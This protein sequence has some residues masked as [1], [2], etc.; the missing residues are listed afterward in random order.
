MSA[1]PLEVT[2]PDWITAHA[3]ALDAGTIDADLVLPVLGAQGLFRIGV[4]REL[5][6]DGGST[7]DAVEAIAAVASHSLTAAFVFWGQRAF[8][9]YLLA[10]PNATLRERWLPSLLA[11]EFAGATGLSN[12]MKFLS[13]IESLQIDARPLGDGRWRLDGKLPW[14]TNLRRAGFVVA[15]AVAFEGRSPAIVVLEHDQPGVRRS[16]DLDL[17]AMRASNTAAVDIDGALI[18][19]GAIIHS[20]ARAFC[21]AVRPAFL[22]LQLGMSI[23]LARAALATA[24]ERAVASHAAA[25]PRIESAAQALAATV[26]EVRAGLADWRFV[27]DAPALFRLRL[28]L[29]ELAQTALNLEL[30]ATGGIAYLRDRN[31]DFSRRWN[32]AAFI[33]VI[34]PSVSQIAGELQRHAARETA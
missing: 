22:A 9:E 13:G 5:G 8:I 28:R 19:D 2:V 16:R 26:A 6:G 20:D 24:R 34:T 33:P 31:P 32:E 18:G 17:I 1:A 27:S 7:A 15:A 12:A 30:E 29:A 23:G 3:L 14:V 25:L 4:P 10:S 21:P 11:G